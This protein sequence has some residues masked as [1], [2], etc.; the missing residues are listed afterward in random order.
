MFAA[1]KL[2]IDGMCCSDDHVYIFHKKHPHVIRI[3]DPTFLHER[4]ISTGLENILQCD[5][6]MCYIEDHKGTHAHTCIIN[7]SAPYPSIRAVNETG[8]I[9][10]VDSG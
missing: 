8:M 6:D 4:Q 9:W 7:T 10:Q 3:F 2:E 1:S 5:V